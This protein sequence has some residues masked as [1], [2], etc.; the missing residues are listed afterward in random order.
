MDRGTLQNNIRESRSIFLEHIWPLWAA[1]L[2]ATQVISTEDSE[3][4]LEREADLSGT[5]AFFVR[6]QN[7]VLIPLASRVEFFD[8]DKNNPFSER[9]WSHYPRFT[10]RLAKA[11]PDGSLVV[12]V[13]CQKRL[14][15]LEDPVSR[16]YLP[17]FTFQSLVR[18]QGRTFEVL[19]TSRVS[20]DKLFEYVRDRELGNL[21]KGVPSQTRAEKDVYRIITAEKLRHAGVEVESKDCRYL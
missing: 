13:E 12:N 5:D 7:G 10:V 19:Q 11:R 14:K 15:A 9:Y 3:K 21:N 20:T 4:P 2:S 18:R 1:E 8:P 16:R 6:N 17:L